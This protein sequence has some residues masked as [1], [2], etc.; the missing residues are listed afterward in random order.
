MAKKSRTSINLVGGSSASASTGRKRKYRAKA[1]SKGL[2]S[3]K[4]GKKVS[5]ARARSTR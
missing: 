2:R 3:K 1:A 4:V 5:R